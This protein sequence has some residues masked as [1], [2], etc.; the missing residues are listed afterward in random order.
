ML[1]DMKVFT[2]D[3]ETKASLNGFNAEDWFAESMDYRG[4]Q[5][6]YVRYTHYP[7]VN[8]QVSFTVHNASS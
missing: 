2:L 7:S 3:K 5:N 1:K 8:E 6:L 4:F